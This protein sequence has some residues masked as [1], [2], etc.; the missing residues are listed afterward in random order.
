MEKPVFLFS[1]NYP[2][3]SGTENVKEKPDS[4]TGQKDAKSAKMGKKLPSFSV[5]QRTRAGAHRR[6]SSGRGRWPSRPGARLAEYH[7]QNTEAFA[8]K[9]DSPPPQRR[10]PACGFH[11]RPAD[12]LRLAHRDGAGT[13]SRDG[14]A[15]R[16]RVRP[17]NADS[18]IRHGGCAPAPPWPRAQHHTW[19]RVPLCPL[20]VQISARGSPGPLLIRIGGSHGQ[21]PGRE[22][23]K[24]VWACKNWFASFSGWPGHAPGQNRKKGKE[25]I[26]AGYPGRR[27]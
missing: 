20:V 16:G 1:Q 15:T 4:K 9:A 21:A 12:D 6:D 3:S 5:Q 7:E 25:L 8:P 23:S 11:R 18:L 27:S 24:L 10:R 13:R 14:R 17:R 2:T 22:P 26:G 19:I